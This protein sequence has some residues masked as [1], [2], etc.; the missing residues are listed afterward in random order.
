MSEFACAVFVLLTHYI[1]IRPIV[2]DLTANPESAEIEVEKKTEAS[3][4]PG[5]LLVQGGQHPVVSKT[6]SANI[7]SIS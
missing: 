2:G 7:I 3:I 5:L 4:G 1:I 6:M